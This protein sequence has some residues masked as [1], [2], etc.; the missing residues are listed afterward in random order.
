MT[1]LYI[2]VGGILTVIGGLLATL[3]QDEIKGWLGR[4]PFVLL[5]VARQ[6]LPSDVRDTLY[7]EWFAELAVKM[8]A[9]SDRPIT[10]L[11]LG[12]RF[13][14]GLIRSGRRVGALMKPIIDDVALPPSTS[15][16]MEIA[17][18]IS[19]YSNASVNTYREKVSTQVF[20]SKW[21]AEAWLDGYKHALPSGSYTMTPTGL[22][23]DPE[24]LGWMV[25]I[26]KEAAVVNAHDLEAT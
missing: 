8:D 19:L 10:R 3:A 11:V 15:S 23:D 4:V 24:I 5:R 25:T 12:M 1:M 21:E 14:V 26:Y 7:D 13:S 20:R 6:R 18:I 22:A 2:L 16:P 17:Q 9:T